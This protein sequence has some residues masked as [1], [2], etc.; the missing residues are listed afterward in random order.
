[1][2]LHAGHT[3]AVTAVLPLNMAVAWS[4]TLETLALLML[5][6]IP[7]RLVAEPALGASEA[8]GGTSSLNAL[9]PGSGKNELLGGSG[10]VEDDSIEI[11][12]V[13][14]DF[15]TSSLGPENNLVKGDQTHDQAA[16]TVSAKRPA[17]RVTSD[18][19]DF[20]LDDFGFG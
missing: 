5:S 7:F 2:Y 3:N 9:L 11:G 14:S 18:T 1:V 12:E 6:S 17:K 10:P 16:A 8:F 19:P 4:E 15:L 13:G 20:S